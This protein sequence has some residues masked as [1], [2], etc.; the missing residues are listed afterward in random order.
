MSWE[1]GCF[2]AL[3][4]WEVREI[5]RRVGDAKRMPFGERAAVLRSIAYDYGVS[6]RTLDRYYA[7]RLETIQVGKYRALFRVPAKQPPKRVSAWERAA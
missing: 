2:L 3:S 7:E 1:Y 6:V 4:E 5:L